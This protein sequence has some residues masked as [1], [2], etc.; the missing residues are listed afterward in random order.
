MK[1][2]CIIGF[3]VLLAII[4][5]GLIITYR[6]I[7]IPSG[8]DINKEIYPITGIDISKH[9]GKVDFKKVKNQNIDFVFIK[10]TEG[11]NYTDN[12]FFYNYLSAKELNIPIG[13]YHFFRFN[14]SGK[15]QAINFL[16]AI[17]GKKFDLPFVL[18]IE[19]WGNPSIKNT[20]EI[21]DDINQF[22]S[23]VESQTGNNLIIY[24]N[25][26]GYNTFISE[27]FEKNDIWICS[28]NKSPNINRRW[29]FWQH[30]HNGKFDFADG[31][32]DIN[33]F[34]GNTYQWQEYLKKLK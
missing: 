18:D 1:K 9:T 14:K 32:V 3:I 11:E 29:T 17:K 15:S 8:V 13:T 25:E 4:A 24:T 22:I 5:V 23:L 28:F 2:G 12:T 31:W 30:S 20:K 34:N 10:A 6:I 19:E 21:I 26:S 16:S 33:T 7:F 27:H